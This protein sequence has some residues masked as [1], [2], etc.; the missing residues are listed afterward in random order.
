[1]HTYDLPNVGNVVG[2]EIAPD[3]NIILAGSDAMD[4]NGTDLGTLQLAKITTGGVII[5][6]TQRTLVV[7]SNPTAMDLAPNGEIYVSSQLRNL[8]LNT[9][10]GSSD[11]VIEKFTS[12]GNP[13]WS[14]S[15]GTSYYD[16]LKEIKFN[17]IANNL[18]M[19]GYSVQNNNFNMALQ[20]TIDTSGA[21]LQ[22]KIY[23]L[24]GTNYNY[25]LGVVPFG[26]N[27]LFVGTA[28]TYGGLLV[29]TDTDGNTGCT[30]NNYPLMTGNYINNPYGIG[31][32]HNP[33]QFN[34]TTISPVYI[35]NPITSTTTCYACSDITVT[36]NVSAYGSYFVGGA[37]QTASGTYT[38]VYPIVGGCDSTVIT[39]LTINL[40][41]PDANFTASA[42]TIFVGQSIDFTDLSTNAPTAWTWTF[43]GAT[44]ASSNAQN[45]TNIVYNTPGCYTVTLTATNPNGNNTQTNTC[46]ITVNPIPV[47]PVANF[48]ASTISITAGQS[49]NFSDLSTNTPTV[50]NWSFP[51]AATT[52][53]TLQ[54]PTNIVYNTPGC[55]Q[56]TLTASNA[57]GSDSEIKPCYINV[58]PVVLVPVANFTSNTTVITAGQ[59]V[60]FTD[61][62]TNTPTSW[63]WTFT[64]ATPTSSTTQNPSNIVYNTAG[65]FQVSLTATNSAGNNT[66]TQTVC[67]ITVKSCNSTCG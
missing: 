45:P 14:K 24:P 26:S 64:G 50:W 30:P 12:N 7:N 16:D 47:T 31:I 39:N 8:N 18:I 41:L 56:V 43:N 58:N 5:W 34:F 23:G 32:Y 38:D 20:A 13:I 59:S 37:L 3:G 52:T 10:H 17:P 51:G 11:I 62:S 36:N 25:F 4:P 1:M 65:C 57:A 2:I 55:Y 42:T 15:F 6:T 49:V 61:L 67:Y 54:N 29:Q 27:I 53:S 40:S 60:N 19:A 33:M 66:S 22:S 21:L 44:P 35:S 9:P 46:Y 48:I 63:S 28:Y